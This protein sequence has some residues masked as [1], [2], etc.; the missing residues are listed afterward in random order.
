MHRYTDSL[1]LHAFFA[2]R[3]LSSSDLHV[4]WLYVCVHGQQCDIH[5][6][7][8][9][10]IRPN[11]QTKQSASA[12]ILRP[13]GPP[14]SSRPTQPNGTGSPPLVTIGTSESDY[15]VAL[16]ESS[17]RAGCKPRSCVHLTWLGQESRPDCYREPVALSFPIREQALDGLYCSCLP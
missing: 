14:Y 13:C 9:P 16:P 7:Y 15:T 17:W 2:M 12:S 3:R 4:E 6:M 5:I 8:S 11:P 1:I 10:E